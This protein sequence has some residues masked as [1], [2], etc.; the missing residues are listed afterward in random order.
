MWAAFKEK[1]VEGST[2]TALNTEAVSDPKD[3]YNVSKLID[4]FMSRELAALPATKDIIVN[5]VNPGE[6]TPALFLAQIL[7]SLRPLRL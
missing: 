4:V 6:S 7:T 1:K 5:N 3:R 2:L